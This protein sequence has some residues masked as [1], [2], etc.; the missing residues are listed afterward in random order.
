MRGE[1]K[2]ETPQ[3]EGRGIAIPTQTIKNH[4]AFEG[5]RGGCSREEK[6]GARNET[7]QRRGLKATTNRKKKVGGGEK[8]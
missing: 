8:L 2:K 5:R 4:Q 7:N 6:G 3:K 1:L